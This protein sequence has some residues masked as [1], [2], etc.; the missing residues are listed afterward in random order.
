M[1][2]SPLVVEFEHGA[3][4]KR[5]WQYEHM[6]VQMEDFRD[7]MEVLMDQWGERYEIYVIYSIHMMLEMT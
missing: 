7:A 3:N 5:D 2:S 1:T 6:V 4:N